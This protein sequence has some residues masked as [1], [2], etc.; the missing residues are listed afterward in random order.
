MRQTLTFIV[1]LAALSGVLAKCPNECSGKGRCGE[2]DLCTCFDGYTG[3]DCSGRKCLYGHAWGDSPSGAEYA[4]DYAECSGQ[5]E[6]DRKTG[7]CK[8]NDGFTGDGC[9][10]S[11]CPNDCSGHG[12]C[13]YIS[14]MQAGTATAAAGRAHVQYSEFVDS[15]RSLVDGWDS[16]KS[17]G[18]KCDP[19]YSGNDCSVRMCPKGNDPLT[20]TV[21]MVGQSQNYYTSIKEIGVAEV[22]KPEIQTVVLSPTRVAATA[23]NY[24]A[25]GGHFTLAYTDMYG[26]TWTT[27]PIRVK[28]KVV[29][30]TTSTI[31]DEGSFSLIA[32]TKPDFGLFKDH[33]NILVDYT[34]TVG[35]GNA[36]SL[37][38]KVREHGAGMQAL[39][40]EPQIP[41]LGS[42][43]AVTLTLVNQDC[44]EIGVTRALTELPNQV[45]PSITVDETIHTETNVFRITFSDIANSG[46]QAML[47]CR[48]AACDTDGCQPRKGAMVAQQL[49]GDT[50]VAYDPDTFKITTGTGGLNVGDS[51]AFGD[52]ATH[53]TA[54]P[55]PPGTVDSKTSTYVILE[56]RNFGS[57]TLSTA[58]KTVKFI[59]KLNDRDKRAAA[60]VTVPCSST[61]C[62]ITGGDG[63]FLCAA[64]NSCGT[65]FKK[66]DVVLVSSQPGAS[67]S[68]SPLD[69]LHLITDVDNSNHKLKLLNL[70]TNA[71]P[72]NAAGNTFGNIVIT[73]VNT[74][75]CAVEETRKGTSE[76]LE[77]SGRGTCDGSTGECACFEGYTSDDCSMQTVLV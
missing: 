67:Q 55:T 49:V 75:P 45:I 60:K 58:T 59:N 11:A 5:G 17:R 69:G 25:I 38:V 29:T 19:Y 4:H 3:L 33:D 37:I 31:A 8:C 53:R 70:A 28:T 68:E 61:V 14:D 36:Q 51:I 52:A 43:A 63:A 24:D 16:K 2:N 26:Q 20:K 32:S 73:R 1:A 34:D 76:S 27:R 6:C 41:V 64:G 48:V 65:T 10:Y 56:E 7:E 39:L 50:N 71:V 21:R 13:E 12:T 77:C 15:D 54:T 23:G 40:V 57:A 74:F 35:G 9:R 46:D 62:G 72:G 30:G 42:A 22:E 44:G 66:D 47:S 18:C